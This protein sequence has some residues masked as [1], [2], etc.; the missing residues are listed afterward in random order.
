[1]KCKECKL[2]EATAI[3]KTIW[4]CEDCYW[5][6]HYKVKQEWQQTI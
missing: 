2:D 4:L 6:V 5:R 3:I 1:M